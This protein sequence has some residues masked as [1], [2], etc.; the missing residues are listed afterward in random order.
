MDDGKDKSEL[1]ERVGVEGSGI[2]ADVVMESE[3]TTGTVI[4]RGLAADGVIGRELTFVE[5]T[6]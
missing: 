1:L 2:V 6:G 5:V 3:L 4:R